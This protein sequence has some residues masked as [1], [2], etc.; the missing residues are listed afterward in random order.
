LDKNTFTEY[1]EDQSFFFFLKKIFDN[2]INNQ[3]KMGRGDK[4][5][6]RGKIW[7]GSH[8]K[9]R[10]KKS[11]SRPQPPKKEEKKNG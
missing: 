8:G 10:P 4:R 11:N 6:T 1:T 5:T 2:L 9:T 3:T 7:R